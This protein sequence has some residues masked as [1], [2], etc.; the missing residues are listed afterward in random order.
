M[1]VSRFL[2][3]IFL[4]PMLAGCGGQS[5]SGLQFVVAFDDARGLKAG[6]TVV[7]N[8]VEIGE[9]K[10]V[11][12]GQGG[13]AE[14]QVRIEPEH[15]QHVYAEAEYTVAK[16]GGLLDTSGQYQLAI[17]DGDSAQRTPVQPGTVIEGTGGWLDRAKAGLGKAGEW[18]SGEAAVLLA[19]AAEWA[20]SPEGQ[21]FQEALKEFTSEA[22]EI[23]SEELQDF[24]DH[25]YPQLREKAIALRQKLEEAGRSDEAQELWEDF[26]RLMDSIKDD[27]EGQDGDN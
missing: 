4:V 27:G 2:R 22:A 26:G 24:R 18:A 8:G 11:G 25:E 6:Q 15:R 9:V 17:K 14:V 1:N 19:K 20:K 7:L 5:E 23:A 21:E 3:A 12:L 13:R 16:I 10:G